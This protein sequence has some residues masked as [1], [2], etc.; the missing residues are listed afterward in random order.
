MVRGSLTWPSEE[1][2]FRTSGLKRGLSLARGSLTWPSEGRGF[3]TNGLR[4]ALVHEH[5]FIRVS[6]LKRGLVPR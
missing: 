4:R 5:G 6:A 3:R 2:D 1:K